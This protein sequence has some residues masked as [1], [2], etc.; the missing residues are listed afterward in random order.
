MYIRLTVSL[1]KPG[2]ATLRLLRRTDSARKGGGELVGDM[3]VAGSETMVVVGDSFKIAEVG[4]TAL[5]VVADVE[6]TTLEGLGETS[7]SG[8]SA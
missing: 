7:S 4:D 6:D 2:S 5:L 3:V 8:N 1:V